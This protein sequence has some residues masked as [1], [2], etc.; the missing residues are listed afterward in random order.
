MKTIKT[1]YRIK[2]ID[3]YLECCPQKKDI[4]ITL[5]AAQ[6][7]SGRSISFIKREGSYDIHITMPKMRVKKKK[8]ILRR[9]ITRIK[10]R[11]ER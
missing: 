10:R 3:T 4:T 5:P 8:N 7:D 1:N 6:Q 9:I 11:V 2:D